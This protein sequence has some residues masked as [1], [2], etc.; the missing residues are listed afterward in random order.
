MVTPQGW[1]GTKL[2][3]F[4]WSMGRTRGGSRQAS[5]M[6]M[7]PSGQ[8]IRVYMLG[9]RTSIHLQE[10]YGKWSILQWRKQNNKR[11]HKMVSKQTS[12]QADQRTR[13]K[14]LQSK[15]RHP[16]LSRAESLLQVAEIS[17]QDCWEEVMR[18]SIGFR[19]FQKTI[20]Q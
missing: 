11:A 4:W 13:A 19:H 8:Q 14:W 9:T 20:E 1:V 17:A 3:V 15:E 12:T 2:C 16:S 5:E 10:L 6:L 18:A 7:T